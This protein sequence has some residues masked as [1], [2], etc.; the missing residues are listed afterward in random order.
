MHCESCHL[1]GLEAVAVSR[2]HRGIYQLKE[3]DRRDLHRIL[4]TDSPCD[5]TG[6]F[7]YLTDVLVPLPLRCSTIL[8]GYA[9][10]TAVPRRQTRV[11]C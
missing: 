3:G 8:D 1:D 2:C 6:Y 7:H 10:A 4:Q 5:L 9:A 11:A